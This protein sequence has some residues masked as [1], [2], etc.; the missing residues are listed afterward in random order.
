MRGALLCLALLLTACSQPQDDA[1]P[2]SPPRPA[3][4]TDENGVVTRTV[5]VDG[6]GLTSVCKPGDEPYVVMLHGLGGDVTNFTGLAIALDE[7]LPDQG[8]CAFDRINAGTS[9]RRDQPRPMGESVSEL[10][11]YLAAEELD[12]PVVLVGFSY[13]G[14]VA[15]TFA[16]THPEDV[17]AM[18]LVDA[19]LAFERELFTDQVRANL[20]TTFAN[21]TE[22]VDVEEAY[23]AMAVTV[24]RW[25][26]VP[27]VYVDAAQQDLATEFGMQGYRPA[28]EAFVA[29]L[30]QGEIVETPTNHLTVI[31]DPGLF[32]AVLDVVEDLDAGR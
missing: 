1:T 31:N 26:D 20:Q 21:N 6:A 30:P 10:D 7:Q 19:P 29:G 28:L 11:F 15:S 27:V 12:R 23:D 32:E 2:A 24:D 9:V 13:G 8:F 25:P 14:M 4:S 3:P 18:V 16:G 5:E 17:A 22:N